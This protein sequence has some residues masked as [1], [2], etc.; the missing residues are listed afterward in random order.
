MAVNADPML[1][2]LRKASPLGIDMY[3]EH[4]AVNANTGSLQM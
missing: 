2:N 4:A 3:N 1:G